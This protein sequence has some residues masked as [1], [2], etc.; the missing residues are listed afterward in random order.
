MNSY[1]IELR[2][3]SG[4]YEVE[5]IKAENKDKA[6]EIARKFITPYDGVQ[7][8]VVERF[9]ARK[10]KMW[11]DVNA[12]IRDAYHRWCRGQKT[13]QMDEAIKKVLEIVKITSPEIPANIVYLRLN[14][15]NIEYFSDWDRQRFGLHIGDERIM[16]GKAKEG[17]LY[18]INVSGDSVMQSIAELTDLLAGKGW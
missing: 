13:E 9:A 16:V 3:Y 11:S 5:Y 15:D 7:E 4:A 12:L 8:I 14:E 2:H 1:R 18:S 17:I 10:V 6:M